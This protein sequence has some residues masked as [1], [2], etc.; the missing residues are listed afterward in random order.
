MRRIFRRS[1]SV[2]FIAALLACSQDGRA[3]TEPQ[4]SAAAPAGGGAPL[5]VDA[6][7]QSPQQSAQQQAQIAVPSQGSVAPLIEKVQGA[8]VNISTT[9]VMKHPPVRGM[10]QSPHGRGQ[11]P[12]GRGGAPG[13]GGGDDQ[14][15][16]DFFDRFF[17]GRPAPQM[18]EE[19]RGSSLGSGFLISPEGFILTN[20]HVVQDA[21]DILVRLTDGGEFKAETVGR[22]PATDVALIKLVNPPKNLPTVVLGDSDAI[23]QGDFVLALGSPF[24]LRNTATLGIISAKHRGR[25]VNPTG[26]YDD[27]LQTDAAINSGNSGGP[28]FNLKGEVVGINTAIVSPQLGSGVGFAV[29]INLAKSILPQLREKGK[30]TRGYAGVSITDLSRDLAQGFG[31]PPDQK[32][33]LV[34]A[35]VPRGP[36]AKAGVQ[37]G[38]VIVAV[39]GKPVAS[40]SD[41]TRTVALVAPGSKVDLT[42]LRGGQKKQV[43]F[44]VAQ[45]PD[46]EEAIARGDTG[47]EEPKGDKSPK[48]GV[49]LGDLTPQIAR[50]VG[51]EPGD[52]VLVRD[53]VASGPA[54]R[55]G[56][57]PG[58]IIVELN[59]KPVKTVQDVAQAIARMKDGEVALLRVRRGQD[60]VYVAVPVGGRQ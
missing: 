55:A 27:F 1:L 19:F 39:N 43:S 51:V 4:R 24:G 47:E 49:T 30:V 60:L 10:P 50:Q 34:Q 11:A 20:N 38:D 16:Q 59:R 57:E 37:P 42:V 31:L 7:Q 54:A 12:G 58:M 18:P 41:L 2:T 9:T 48:L 23:R 52:G 21:T 35:V 46:D 44:A 26:T 29:P 45:R 14:E 32:G 3:A 8:V 22:D 15:F 56:I 53:V 17:G 5:Y 6:A 25:E 28:L 40:G 36:A 33:A 13:Q